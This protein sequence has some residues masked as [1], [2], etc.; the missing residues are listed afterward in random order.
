MKKLLSLLCAVML[1]AALPLSA[2]ADVEYAVAKEA[3]RMHFPELTQW[4]DVKDD[5]DKISLLAA[6]VLNDTLAGLSDKGFKTATADTILL[7]V[8]VDIITFDVYIG[9]SCWHIVPLGKEITV[10]YTPNSN[11]AVDP[12]GFAK[13]MQSYGVYDSYLVINNSHLQRG[14]QLIDAAK[15]VESSNDGALYFR[16]ADKV[17]PFRQGLASFNYH[18]RG[19]FIRPDGTTIFPGDWNATSSFSKDAELGW[20]YI[21]PYSYGMAYGGNWG[22]IDTEGNIVVPI[23]YETPNSCEDGVVSMKPKGETR[24]T[25]FDSKIGKTYTFSDFDAENWRYSNGMVAVYKGPLNEKGNPEGG[26]WGFADL[27]GNVIIPLEWDKVGSQW[28]DGM[29]TVTRGGKEGVI[30]QTGT[31]VI[32]C[33]WDNV[34]EINDG[35]FLVE[36]GDMYFVIDAQGSI[37]SSFSAGYVVLDDYGYVSTYEEFNND[38]ALY[39]V[40]GDLVL[41]PS[42][43][44]IRV[45]DGNTVRVGFKNNDKTKV[46]GVM[47]LT[48]QEMI[49]PLIY[50]T[51]DNPADDMRRVKLDGKY[52]YLDMDFNTAISPRYEEATD[53]NGGYACVK[54]NGQW[55][56]IDKTGAVIF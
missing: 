47:N 24:Y 27:E 39:T 52:G 30:D 16:N 53:F 55:Y 4:S 6:C 13:A 2:M 14:Q 51:L 15:S 44:D 32:P 28:Y 11:A 21:G 10:T 18:E 50:E 17:G 34:N 35:Y 22:L 56:I 26:K 29:M 36:L 38:G 19:G 5:T 48:T 37:L 33:A 9:S 43:Y 54:L 40:N 31:I 12:I 45:Y 49:V 23:A 25:F 3:T 41:S 42:W 7:M 8:T 1:L 20:V 46:F